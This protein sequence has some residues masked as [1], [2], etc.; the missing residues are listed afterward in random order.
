M[1]VGSEYIAEDKIKI[2]LINKN[3]ETKSPLEDMTV[4]W[5][6]NTLLSFGSSAKILMNIF[7]S[8]HTWIKE[9]L[10]S[11]YVEEYKLL[12]KEGRHKQMLSIKQIE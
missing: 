8:Q 3:W 11:T 5:K 9:S 1:R 7:I 4:D 10:D 2:K 12:E 6:K